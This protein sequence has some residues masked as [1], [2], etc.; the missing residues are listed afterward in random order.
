MWKKTRWVDP[1]IVPDDFLGGT[2]VRLTYPD[3]NVVVGKV[4]VEPGIHRVGAR[5]EAVM[6][7]IS[8]PHSGDTWMNVSEADLELWVSDAL[9]PE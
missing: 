6:A 1:D 2:R 9:T 8:T 7:R 5:G 3:G 4:T